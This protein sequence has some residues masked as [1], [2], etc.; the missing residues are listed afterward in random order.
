[1]KILVTG[2]AGFIGSH[3]TEELLKRG[4]KVVGLDNINDYYSP[5][6]KRANLDE[7]RAAEL[8]ENFTFCEGD[9]R[10][11]TQLSELFQ[12]H[13][14]EAVVNLGAMAG[15]RA[16]IEKPQVYFDVN[17][18]GTLNLLLECVEHKVGNFVLA[19]TSSAYGNTE[20]VPFVETDNC[21]RP[22]APYAASKRAAEMLAYTY[23]HLFQLNTTVLRFFTVYGPRSRPDMM[24]HKV[25]D[26]IYFETPCK[27]YNN[28][29]MWR[30]WTFV[31]DIVA[32]VANAAERPLGYEVINIGRG[33]M[34]KLS[35][36]V[37]YV[38]E[39]TGKS[40]NLVAA[41]KIAADVD[42]TS[43]DVSKARRLLGY[44]PKV[45]VKEGV[46]RLTDWY[47]TSVVAK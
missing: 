33:E 25:L 8:S 45:S 42:R 1:M 29:E 3:T 44:E 36:F 16:S 14:F 43:A 46:R 7:V 23:H 5:D 12:E 20:V 40:T 10:D 41:P 47:K 13:Q 35:D 15:V 19:S 26:N 21:D 31:S 24:A 28:G 2:A 39:Y 17:L 30:D 9:L 38:E 6:R 4:H 27:I 32:G 22:L 18:T 11:R 37:Q 34:V